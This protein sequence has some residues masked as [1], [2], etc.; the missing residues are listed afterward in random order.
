MKNSDLKDMTPVPSRWAFSFLLPLLLL[1][2]SVGCTQ[3]EDEGD[4]PKEV[5]E[6]MGVDMIVDM[7][8][9]DMGGSI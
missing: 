8:L 4:A 1:L 5:I 9:P 2:M 6:D 3:E 7:R